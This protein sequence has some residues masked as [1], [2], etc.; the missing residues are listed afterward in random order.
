MV[1]HY[2]SRAGDPH[3]HLHLQINARVFAAN[4]WRGLHSVGVV[5]SIE[6]LNGIG[7]AA[8]MCDP[9][10]R[11]ALSDHGYTLDP[12]SGEITELARYAGA[13]SARASQIGRNVDRYEADWRTE[14]PGVEPGPGLRQ[15]WDRRAW[16]DAR[17]DKVVPTDGAELAETWREELRN[18]GFTP[19][20]LGVA[21]DATPIARIDREGVTRLV[22][23]RLGARR[24]SWNAADIRGE[25]EQIVAAVNIVAAP[26]VRRELVE[27]LTG[28]T[29]EACHRLLER[30]DV[31]EHVRALTSP[32]VLAVEAELT[33]RLVARADDYV[34]F[35][36]APRVWTD[37]G[38]DK[39]QRRVVAALAGT[40]RLLVIEGAAG[41]GKTATLVA[42]RELVEMKQRRLVVVTPTLKAA[43]VAGRQVGTEAVSAAWLIYQCG[44][45]WN[46]DGARRRVA[47]APGARVQ[48][49]RGDV[50]VVDEAGMLDQ[51]TALALLTVADETGARIAFLG[52]R[53]QLPAV[54]RGGVLDHAARWARPETRLDLEVVH[55]FADPEYAK[56]SLL[57]RNGER[58]GEVFD[59]LVRR[60]EI[61]VHR[62]E[63]ER[64]V[65]LT[66]TF[67]T[68]E[69]LIV[70]DT[71]EQV[72]DLN[73]AIRDA[74]LTTGPTSRAAGETVATGSLTTAAGEQIGIG[75]RV[76][77]RRNDRDLDV[78]NRDTWTVTGT[79]DDGNLHVRGRS[80]MRMLPS[81]YV[82]RYVELAYATTVHGAQG[83]TVPTAHMLIGETTGA[84]AA[85]VGMT[86]GRVRN[87]AHLVAANH[88]DAR[89]QWIQ[90][91]ARDRADL[92]PA[93]AAAAAA[94]AI[95]R[96]GPAVIEHHVAMQR[97]ALRQGPRRVDPAPVRTTPP[98]GPAI[99]F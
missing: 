10:F 18:L 21:L 88:G 79:D 58:S 45:R 1:R 71:R 84:A 2:T 8:V 73:A 3:R 97:A 5:D 77:T 51:D 31:P 61:V 12:A 60:G 98:P 30:D 17:P 75:D 93:D 89:D 14:H 66:T 37:R 65:A 23:A 62:S 59:A 55:R 34:T 33:A 76:A 67:T 39:A 7:H 64:L 90:A 74:R 48:L 94:E 28:R 83:E 46:Q 86:R 92:G 47:M 87:V 53:H 36:P 15:A 78:A 80:G 95:E 96:Y 56:I 13:F 40:S 24:S 25:V 6:A 29:V 32:E 42:A 50:L 72:R 70:A 38:L 49:L 82:H 9:E 4:R 91:F 11:S 54:G 22:L 35:E 41:A 57:M 63:V 19:P 16:A 85:Y 99:G 69:T 68:A 44:Y 81:A 43:R 20:P 52:D 26:R 27:D